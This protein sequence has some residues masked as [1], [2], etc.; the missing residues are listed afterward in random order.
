MNWSTIDQYQIIFV[1]LWK[2]LQIFL[3]RIVMQ[4]FMGLNESFS[5]I[6][7]QILLLD[8]LPTINKV[9]SLVLQEKR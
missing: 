4:F 3:N 6:R 2:H 5:H 8:H 7:G 9:F 1:E